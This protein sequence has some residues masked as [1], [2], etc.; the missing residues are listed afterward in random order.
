LSSSFCFPIFP[1]WILSTPSK[2]QKAMRVSQILLITY[3]NR[4]DYSFTLIVSA[5]SI[6]HVV[7]DNKIT[8]NRITKSTD[9]S[10]CSLKFDYDLWFTYVI[11]GFWIQK[12]IRV[13][14][15]EINLST[16]CI[17]N[18]SYFF[19]FMTAFN[20]WYLNIINGVN[21]KLTKWLFWTFLER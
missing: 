14:K 21:F 11:V 6:L 18:P 4:R 8:S 20:C 12:R 19:H 15:D 13:V 5:C 17:L 16:K 1:N 3:L 9:P 7:H 10:R 2:S